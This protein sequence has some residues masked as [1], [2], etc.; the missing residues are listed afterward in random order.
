MKKFLSLVLSVALLGTLGLPAAAAAESADTRLVKLTE[1]VKATLNLDTTGYDSFHGELEENL[2]TPVWQLQ[3]SGSAGE[4]NIS[5]TE[6]GKILSYYRYQSENGG[7]GIWYPYPGR[8]FGASLPKLS[9]AD[10]QKTAQA[11]L[12]RVLTS[13][14]ETAQFQQE[15]RGGLSATSHS[16]NGDVLEHGLP[17]PFRFYISVSVGDNAVTSFTL[18]GEPQN[19]L[20]GIPSATASADKTKAG[21]A[22]KTTQE[23]YLEY[24]LDKDG[25]TAVLRYLPSYGNEYYVDAQTGKLVDLTALG[26]NLW[27]KGASTTAGASPSATA[28]EKALSTAEQEGVAKLEGVLS[29]EALDATARKI[30]A[31]G[32]S[33]YT[34][35]NTAYRLKGEGDGVIATL[36]YAYKTQDGV[37]RRI[38]TLDAKTGMLSGVYSSR[39]WSETEK[40]T[41]TLAQSQA[42][43]EAFLKEQVPVQFAQTALYT[44]P[45]QQVSTEQAVHTF[46]FAQKE[47]GYFF[48]GSSLSVEIDG[49]DGTVS[50]Y[51]NSFLEDITFQSSTGIISMDAARSAWFET[52]TVTL[53]YLAVPEKLDLSEPKWKPLIEMGQSYLYT[54][55]LAYSLER[56]T[57]YLG[58]DAKTGTPVREEQPAASTVTYNDLSGHWVRAQATTLAEYGVGWLG[59]SLLPAKELKQRDLL[60]LLVSTS[61]YHYDG[62]EESAE[63]LYQQAYSMGIL[64]KADRDDHAPVNR[65]ALTKLLLDSAGYSNIAGLE[66]IFKAAFTDQASIPAQYYGY[67]AVAQGLGIAKGD[68]AGNFAP[69]RTATRAEAVSMLYQLMS[70]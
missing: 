34:L 41:L 36:Q 20:G 64:K 46:Q 29:G 16:F 62:T 48:P 22:L 49:T 5:A 27:N 19:Y 50:H 53:G 31:L 56:E 13:G 70:R 32:L 6:E 2:V 60:A 55:K 54:R 9:R 57:W 42:K 59:G 23:L 1:K 33:K 25:K 52:Y 44:T 65:A 17:S 38:V 66:G 28:D 26:Q 14:T 39:P 51:S 12:N 24:V 43:A 63:Q 18:Q 10:A 40:A 68:K 4:L 35:A 30:S 8:S 47:N 3:W 58:I 7:D 37:Y 15:T 21:E 61:G 69:L 67:A 11:F 45:G